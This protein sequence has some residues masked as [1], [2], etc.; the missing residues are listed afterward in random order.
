MSRSLALMFHCFFPDDQSVCCVRSRSS[1]LEMAVGGGM[2]DERANGMTVDF[3]NGC[4]E[5]RTRSFLQ[6]Q[7]MEWQAPCFSAEE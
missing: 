3:E 6:E 4:L 5:V 1:E 2:G 7:Y